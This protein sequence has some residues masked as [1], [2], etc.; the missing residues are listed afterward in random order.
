[1]GNLTIEANSD[2]FAQMT[3]A[4]LKK[5]VFRKELSFIRELINGIDPSAVVQN[6]NGEV[7]FGQAPYLRQKRCPIQL[8]NQVIGWLSADEKAETLA[9]LISHL[10]QRELEKRTLAQEL[11]T[12]YKEISLLFSL[13]EKIIDSID[14]QEVA[15]LALDEACR[16]LHSSGGAL[17]L[18]REGTHLLE[19][20][21]LI[22]NE[23]LLTEPIFL[24]CGF[25]GKLVA[26]G[27][28]EIVNHLPLSEFSTPPDPPVALACVPLK[29]KDTV[30]G[31]IVLTRADEGLYTAEDLKLLTTLACQV[32]GVISALLHERRLK[33]S[34]QNALLLRL[35][36]QIRESLELNIILKTTVSEV[37]KLLQLDRC[38]FCWCVANPTPAL[39]Q[40]IEQVEIVTE[41]YCPSLSPLLGQYPAADLGSLS[42]QFLNSE[43]VCIDDIADSYD[44]AT[45]R[46]LQAQTLASLLAIPIRTRSG[47]VGVLGCGVSY[48]VRQWS[49]DQVD[50]LQ[51]VASQLAIALEQAELYT[52]SQVAAKVAEDKAQQLEAALE[53]LKQAQLQLIQTEKLS[54]IGQMVAG[55]AHEINNPVTFIHGNLEYLNEYAKSL[56]HLVQ[57]YQQEYPQQTPAI[58]AAIEAAELDFLVEDLPK[59]VAS[60]TM[61]ATRIQD[62]VLSLKN[63]SRLDQAKPQPTN[64][65]EGIDSTLLILSHRLKPRDAFPGIRV[66]KE[67]GDLPWVDCYAG[68]L[69]QVFMNILANAVDALEEQAS[70]NEV[71]DAANEFSPP[72]IWICTAA[73][74]CDRVTIRIKDNGPSIPAANLNQLFDPFFTTKPSGKGTGLGLSISHQIVVDHHGGQ[75]VCHSENGKGTEFVIEIPIRPVKA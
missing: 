15:A 29:H 68:Q 63:F 74:V 46:F 58:A 51:A 42:Q 57:I 49:R 31:A 69:N 36:N 61:G 73:N 13:S 48:E 75:L 4:S 16:L 12:K 50:L 30:M 19:Q 65:H 44:P 11:L 25:I 22:G 20:I 7:L 59:V 38:W 37:Y 2:F 53:N 33:E 40:Q 60:M 17:L 62:I 23:R 47:K 72:T 24:G 64:I 6:S 39:A 54:G 18:Q 70:S 43:I 41:V 3:S 28:S 14:V 35:S 26:T 55:V 1:M 8:E 71:S 67:Y 45:Q 10:A 21:A 32:A 34:Q 56:L 27:Q 52:K 9:T 66:V 5:L